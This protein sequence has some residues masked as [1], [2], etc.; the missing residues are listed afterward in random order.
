MPWYMKPTTFLQVSERGNK[1]TLT[2]LAKG[3]GD[4]TK[5]LI[6]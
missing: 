3:D 2:T 1:F 6:L 4:L 5:C